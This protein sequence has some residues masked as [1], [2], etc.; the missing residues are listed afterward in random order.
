MEKKY[1]H[2]EENPDNNVLR[3]PAIQYGEQTETE[4][5]F[6]SPLTEEELK[7]AITGE[8]LLERVLP[9]IKKFFE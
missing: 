4:M 5:T 2:E 6:S 7:T 3:E 1:K 8:E 9:R